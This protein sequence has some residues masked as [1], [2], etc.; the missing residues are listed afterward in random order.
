MRSLSDALVQFLA[1]ARHEHLTRAA[2]EL[3]VSQPTLSRNMAKLE[4][5][6]GSQL[7]DRRARGFQLNAAGRILLSHAERAKAELDDAAL[8]IQEH[9]D[10]TARTISIGFLGTFGVSLVPD[11]VR[12]F[13]A[14]QM[15][16]P[17]FRLLQ[18]SA[19]FLRDRLETRD[20]E[21]CIASPRF[22]DANLEWRVLFDE[23][24]LAVV[25]A[26]SPL[27][28]RGAIDLGELA[29]QP[30]VML[31]PE[32]GLRKI[33]EDLCEKAGFQPII[34]FEVEEVA[35]L[36][37][38]VGAG[39]GVTIAPRPVLETTAL[40]VDLPV[41]SPPAHRAVGIMWRRDRR[42]SSEAMAFRNHVLSHNY[43]LAG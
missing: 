37:G 7:F 24:L 41:Q 20:I 25:P 29:A 19:P 3:N 26:S 28:G 36:R 17:P 31:K 12:S 2:N 30:F 5:L 4:K 35:T 14:K 39:V 38:L 32:Y 6:F 11:L 43:D 18:G 27:A 40:T 13:N 23:E 42:M 1:V 33:A 16:P 8:A 10:A 34:A 9:N 22:P 21:L 15:S